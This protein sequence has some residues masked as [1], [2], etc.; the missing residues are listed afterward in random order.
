MLK[1]GKSSAVEM[2]KMGVKHVKGHCHGCNTKMQV[3]SIVPV[4]RWCPYCGRI[5]SVLE[6]T[7]A[8]AK[9]VEVYNQTNLT[10]RTVA[11]NPKEL[12]KF[13]KMNKIKKQPKHMENKGNAGKSFK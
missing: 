8:S 1:F 13:Q 10:L 2:E 9:I 4:L 7:G 5:E 11:S 3:I 12:I 6:G